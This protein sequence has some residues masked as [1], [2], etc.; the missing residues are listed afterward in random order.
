MNTLKS[1]LGRLSQPKKE[2]QLS[3]IE[4]YENYRDE[5]LSRARDVE[6]LLQ[7]MDDLGEQA[8]DAIVA[9]QEQYDALQQADEEFM[10]ARNKLADAMGEI[11]TRAG[12]LGFAPS[13]L[14]P[15]YQ[16]SV[17]LSLLTFPFNFSMLT[18]RVIE[19]YL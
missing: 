2:V 1:V 7:N 10:E 16:E 13:D 12:E 9:V 8:Y 17:D 5:A 6:L 14:M 4:D 11:E 3:A 19:E 18:N 15:D